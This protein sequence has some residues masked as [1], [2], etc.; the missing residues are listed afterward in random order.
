MHPFA[1]S[2]FARVAGVALAA[3]LLASAGCATAPA[4]APAPPP[5]RT[6]TEAERVAAR[7]DSARARARQDS[8]RDAESARAA[9]LARRTRVR[10]AARTDTLSIRELRAP[11]R[12]C[13]GGDVTLGTNLDTAWARRA[14]R[15]MRT[16]FH[17]DDEP[18][19]LL[20]PLRPL[21]SSA[22][23]V[24]LNVESAI[25][26][27]PA[28]SKCGRRSRN[29]FAFRSPPSSAPA[30][31]ALASSATV[32]GNV[33]NNH[34]RDAGARGHERTVAALAQA[35]VLV[36][37][38]D[39]LATPVPT[40]AGDTIGVLGFYTSSETPDAR[41]T[42]AVYRHVARAFERYPV[43]IATMHLG[44]EGRNAQRTVDSTE[45]FLGID[46][47]NPVA[48]ADAAVRGGA[49]L[50]VGHGPHVLRAIEWRDRGALIA[51]SLGN[52]LT[53][54]PFTLTEPLNRGAVLCT[55]IGENGRVRAAE[56]GST[57]QLAP[58]VLQADRSARA[59]AIADSLG[60]LDFPE[61][62]AR[63]DVTGVLRAR[64]LPD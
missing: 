55:T 47:G 16:Q 37:G 4:P 54:G 50:V 15:R 42:A 26:A 45:L 5:V 6:P 24:L 2:R 62:G 46:R 64:E 61:T 28:P 10:P 23:I 18:A 56:V 21:V 63:A 44:A 34:A 53:Y 31:R 59:A 60:R 25:G 19:T 14:A 17:L 20:A 29:C 13:A 22:D 1:T 57:V 7:A 32:V 51:Y 33:A 48:F 30:L 36:T 27:G 8:I 35:G 11:V 12:V 58:G 43:V 38:D 52:L 40:P 39:T 9:A 3:T 41:D 49:A